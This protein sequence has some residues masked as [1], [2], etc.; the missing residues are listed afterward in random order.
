MDGAQ[1]ADGYLA[2][3]DI[4][5]AFPARAFYRD[6]NR[7]EA[8]DSGEGE[9]FGLAIVP[10]QAAKDA[11]VFGDFLIGADSGAI[12]QTANFAGCGDVRPLASQ[13]AKGDRFCVAAGIG[14][15]FG[16]YPARRA[17]RMNPIEALRFE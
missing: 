12:L 17:S 16:Y 5:G 4:L 13:F 6:A 9:A 1:S 2:C 15:V 11:D 14:I 7:G 3:R 8:V 10:P